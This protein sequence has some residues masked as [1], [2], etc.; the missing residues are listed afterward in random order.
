MPTTNDVVTF[1]GT[2]AVWQAVSAGTTILAAVKTVDELVNNSAV[3]QDDDA[4]VVSL[5]ASKTY[6]F[7]LFAKFSSATATPD[8]KFD[9]SGPT[10]AHQWFF[11]TTSGGTSASGASAALATD[12]SVTTSSTTGVLVIQGIAV[13]VG[14]VSLQFRWAQNT[15]T[16]ED[17]KILADS[18]LMATPLT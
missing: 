2:Q 5:A 13:T 18:Y 12:Q 11:N 17:T 7:T 10:G 1:D 6:S 4:L 8:L 16:V 9:F 14:A 15:A 3:L